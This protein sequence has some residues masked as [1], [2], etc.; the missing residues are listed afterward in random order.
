M[1]YSCQHVHPPHQ[2]GLLLTSPKKTYYSYSDMT[3]SCLWPA[4]E[5][6]SSLLI[7]IN[8]LQPWLWTHYLISLSIRVLTWKMRITPT[9]QTCCRFQRHN[10][11]QLSGCTQHTVSTGKAII[12]AFQVQ[13]VPSWCFPSSSLL[14][15]LKF[16]I[17]HFSCTISYKGASLFF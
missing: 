4:A 14:F 9:S 15:P 3:M 1:K 10:P 8:Y 7:Q 11:I 16:L 17:W 13:Q 12:T 2:H 5:A 6:L